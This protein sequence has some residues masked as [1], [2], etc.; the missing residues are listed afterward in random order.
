MGA[1]DAPLQRLQPIVLLQPLGSVALA[2][3]NHDEFPF[4]QR[5]L[6][7]RRT[8]IGPQDAAA[9]DQGIGFQLD[10]LAKAAFLR[11][12]WNIQAFAFH[13]ELPAM[14]GTANAA[15]LIAAEPKRNA[16]MGTE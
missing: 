2:A 12:G 15:L 10:L 7:L 3:W 11:L 14:I 8:H 4:R 16:P 9:L 6:L 13:V 1:V 5:R